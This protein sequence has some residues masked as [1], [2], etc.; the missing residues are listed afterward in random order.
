MAWFSN[1]GRTVGSYPALPRPG[2]PDLVSTAPT[3]SH[4]WLGSREEPELVAD[5]NSGA[6]MVLKTE[7]ELTDNQ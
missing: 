1:R 2:I 5:L 4:H 6:A 3:H 7:S